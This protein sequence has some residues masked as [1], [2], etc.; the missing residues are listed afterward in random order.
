[1]GKCDTVG[2]NQLK[3]WPEHFSRL[4]GKGHPP[5]NRFQPAV[6]MCVGEIGQY[7]GGEN[8]N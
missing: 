7:R 5:F 2:W 4:C 1:M 8:G 3:G 6:S